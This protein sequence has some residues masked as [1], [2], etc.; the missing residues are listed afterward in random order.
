MSK[1][2]K[3]PK[4]FSLYLLSCV[5][6]G[7]KYVGITTQR[8]SSRWAGHICQAKAS[9]RTPL[10][11][12]INKYGRNSFVLEHIA[13]ANS[14]ENLC[15][16]EGIVIAQYGTYKPNGYNLTFGGE[17]VLGKTLSPEQCERISAAKRGKNNITAIQRENMTAGVKLYW[18][19]EQRQKQSEIT[20]ARMSSGLQKLMTEKS[21]TPAARAKVSAANKGKKR[22]PESRA[23]MCVAQKIAWK[24]RKLGKTFKSSHE[25]FLS[26]PISPRSHYV[27]S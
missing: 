1:K 13:S 18:S 8:L 15:A 17:G 6:T 12:A 4:G 19:Q 3:S 5:P 16:L 7:K 24:S 25:Y 27:I 11:R 10:Q 21:H 9:A 23:R 22:S 26:K 2:I 20:K 14:W